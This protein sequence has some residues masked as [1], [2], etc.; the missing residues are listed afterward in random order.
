[1]TTNISGKSAQALRDVLAIGMLNISENARMAQAKKRIAKY[2]AE[3]TAFHRTMNGPDCDIAFR[4]QTDVA[5][6]RDAVDSEIKSRCHLNFVD[7]PLLFLER[8]T[9]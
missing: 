6:L 5:R 1:M 4:V 9:D 3:A 8:V 7:K 2:Q